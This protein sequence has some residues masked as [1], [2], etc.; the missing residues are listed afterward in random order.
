[1]TPKTVCMNSA[2]LGF[3]FLSVSYLYFWNTTFPQNNSYAIPQ[4]VKFFKREQIFM[5][6]HTVLLNH[7]RLKSTDFFCNSMSDG[8]KKK[9]LKIKLITQLIFNLF[10]GAWI[11]CNYCNFGAWFHEFFS[12]FFLVWPCDFTIFAPFFSIF[13]AQALW[14]CH[15]WKRAKDNETAV[16]SR[17]CAAC[18]S[19]VVRRPWEEKAKNLGFLAQNL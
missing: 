12:L 16:S 6:S 19:S 17:L 13:R 7:K 14:R 3:F 9:K 8:L 2:G 5:E 15:S 4:C 18:K 1:M 11:S 10:W